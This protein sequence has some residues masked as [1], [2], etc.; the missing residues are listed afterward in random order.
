MWLITKELAE[1]VVDAHCDTHNEGYCKCYHCSQGAWMV[2]HIEH[3]PECIVMRAKLL[4]AVEYGVQ[5]QP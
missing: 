1:A 4:L 2:E 5:S 3:T